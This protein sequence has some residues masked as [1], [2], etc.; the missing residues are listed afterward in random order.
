MRSASTLNPRILNGT[1]FS[2]C[3]TQVVLT[4]LNK[5]QKN[6]TVEK[7]TRIPTTALAA[8]IWERLKRVLARSRKDSPGLREPEA[9]TA[10]RKMERRLA[11]SAGA[12]SA[13]R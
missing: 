13:R 8:S 1:I 9:L 2:P 11:E 7:I 3:K 6:G 5:A 10:A 12:G 4:W